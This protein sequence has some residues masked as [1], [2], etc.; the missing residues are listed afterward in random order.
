MKKIILILL[1][2]LNITYAKIDYTDYNIFKSF[3]KKID[4]SKIHS[5]KEVFFGLKN[6]FNLFHLNNNYIT[7]Y[8]KCLE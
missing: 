3:S 2:L 8:K 7:N 1:T 6:N 4:L 5:T